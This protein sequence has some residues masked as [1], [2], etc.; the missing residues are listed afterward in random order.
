LDLI[1][2]WLASATLKGQEIKDPDLEAVSM[3]YLTLV[4]L[5]TPPQL[6]IVRLGIKI[7]RNVAAPEVFLESL[8]H[9]SARE[10]PTWVWDQPDSRLAEGHICYSTQ[11]HEHMVE[12][13]HLVID[14]STVGAR[15]RS[16]AEEPYTDFSLDTPVR[17]TLSSGSGSAKAIETPPVKATKPRKPKSKYRQESE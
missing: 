17:M 14:G 4:D 13:P 1:T 5:V 3:E 12:W 6:L 11:A 9:R 8:R 2:A 16:I 15:A 7:A 10:R